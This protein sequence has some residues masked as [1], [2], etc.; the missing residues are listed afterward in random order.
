M[1]P[2]EVSVTHRQ[3]DLVVPFLLAHDR[4]PEELL[5]GVE[6]VASGIHHT[7][8]VEHAPGPVVVFTQ[9]PQCET[10]LG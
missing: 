3:A 9:E 4:L 2:A 8:G 10:Q 1:K 6:I 7:E 5:G